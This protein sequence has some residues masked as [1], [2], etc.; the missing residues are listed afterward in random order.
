MAQTNEIRNE[1][2]E[3]T[4]YTTEIQQIVRDCHEQL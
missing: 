2:R 3:V 4:T 1:R